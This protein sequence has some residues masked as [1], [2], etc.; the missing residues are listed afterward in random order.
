MGAW[1]HKKTTSTDSGAVDSG[2]G[3]LE[4]CT[5][6]TAKAGEEETL[7]SGNN[8]TSSVGLV[9]RKGWGLTGDQTEAGRALTYMGDSMSQTNRSGARAHVR[10]GSWWNAKK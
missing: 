5:V 8:A 9:A 1:F 2:V 10:R 4:P 3:E 6:C 7:W